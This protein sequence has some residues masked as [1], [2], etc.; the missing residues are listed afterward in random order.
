LEKDRYDANGNLASYNGW[1]YS[2]DAQNRLKTVKQGAT[3]MA[4]YWY[5]GLNRQITRKISGGA[6]TFN[7]WDG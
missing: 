4:Q 7:V 5:D 1:T 2:Y 6:P 3:T